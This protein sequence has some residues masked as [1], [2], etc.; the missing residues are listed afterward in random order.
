MKLYLECLM[1]ASGDMLMSALYE[2]LHDKESFRKKMDGLNLPGVTLSYCASTKSGITGTR[3]AVKV[4]GVEEKSEDVHTH[5]HNHDNGHTHSHGTENGH[6]HSHAPKGKNSNKNTSD[7]HANATNGHKKSSSGHKHGSEK[8]QNHKHSGRRYGYEEII[9]LIR[10]LGLAENVTEDALAVYKIIGQAEAA[11]HGL[12]LNEIHLH[13]LGSLDA[14]ADIVGCCLLINMLGVTEIAASPVHVGSGHIRCEH[15]VLPVP[16]PAAAE[17]LKGIPFYSGQVKGELCTPT[18]AALLNHFVSRFGDMAPMTVLKIGYGMGAKDF[19]AANCLRAFLC[20][21]DAP[22][23]GTRDTVFEISCNLDD[24][25][26]EAV[27]AVFGLLSENGALDVYTVPIMMKKNRPAVMLSCLCEESGREVL[28]RLMLEHTSSL[29]VRITKYNRNI[30]S[31]STEAVS[32]QYGDIRVKYAQG[33]GILKLKP[34]YD[35]VLEASKR[36]GVPFMAVYE[37]AMNNPL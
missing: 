33:F 12:P 29:G 7:G 27:G 2:L 24:M 3:I 14:V 23:G 36:H 16:A 4:S 21:G 6:T 20:E 32:T 25:T 37:A 10:S 11:V 18:G 28:A 8:G 35:D 5:S 17:I 13:E 34:E 26:P 1:G 22:D 31:R 9:A 30:M 19:E 15:G